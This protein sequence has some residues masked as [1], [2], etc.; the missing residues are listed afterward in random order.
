MPSSPALSRRSG[1][2]TPLASPTTTRIRTHNRF[3][4]Y[5]GD[6]STSEGEDDAEILRPKGKLAARMLSGNTEPTADSESEK[7]SPKPSSPKKTAATKEAEDDGEDEYEIIAPRPRKLKARLQRSATP[8]QEPTATAPRS[9]SPEQNHS[10]APQEIF[11]SPSKP[12]GEAGIYDE[13]LP[14]PSRLAKNAKFEALVAKKRAERLTREAEEARKKA[15]RNAMIMDDE[16]PE[17]FTDDEGGHKLTQEGAKSRPSTRKASKKALEEMNR[18]TQRMTRALQLAHEAKIKKKITKSTLFER[19]NFKPAGAAASTELPKEKAAPVS[20]SRA[21]TPASVQQSDAERK[22][23]D[24]PPSSPPE[25]EKEKA[26]PAPQTILQDNSDVELPTVGEMA[27]SA[28][29][30]PKKL[31]KGKGKA[32][33][34]E[35]EAEDKAKEQHQMPRVK[36]NLRVKFPQFSV[37]A[38]TATTSLDDEDDDLQVQM[39]SKIDQ[40]LSRVNPNQNKE[41]KALLNLRRLAQLD[42]PDKKAGPVPTKQKFQQNQKPVMTVGELQMTLMQRAKAQAKLERERHLESLRA[43][44]IVV[45]TAEEREKEEQEVED[46]V[47]KARREAEEIM[48]KERADAKEERR[49]KRLENGEDPLD[50]DDSDYDGESWIGEGE[51][52]AEIELS[53]SEE[54]NEDEEAEMED[55]G[56]LIDD[57]TEEST[58]EETEEVDAPNSD[59]E[60]GL[61]TASSKQ[62]R[63]RAWK[64]TAVLSDDEDEADEGVVKAT[65]N[66]KKILVKSPSVRQ[67]TSPSVPTSVLRSATKTFIPGLPVAGPAGLGLTQIF[68]GTMDDSQMGSAPPDSPSQPRPTFD[69]GAF[70]DSQFSQSVQEPADGIVLNS[71]PAPG[72][73]DAET[74]GIQIQFSQSQVHGFDSFLRDET[75]EATQV[76]ELIEPTQDSGFKNFTPLQRS[77]IEEPASTVETLPANQNSQADS[78]LVRRTGKLRRRAEAAA[79]ENEDQDEIMKDDI[80]T[81]AASSA[82]NAFFAMKEAARKEK[83]RKRKEAFDKKKSKAREMVEEQAEESED[84]YAGLG[85]ADGEDTDEEDAKS[86]QEMIDDET[87]DKAEDERKLAAFYADRERAADEKQVNKLFHDITTGLLRRKRAG[88]WD[89]LDDEDDGG[90]ALRRM[91]RRQFAKMQRAL[92][93]DERISK[94]AENPRNQAFLKTIEDRG[95]DDEMDFIW[96]PPPPAPG[97]DSQNSATGDSSNE[98]VTIPDSQPQEQQQQQQSTNPR[99]TKPGFTNKK[100]PSNIGE[101]RESLSNL[102]EDGPDYKSS[103]VI[104]ATILHSDSE[105]EGPHPS[106]ASS[107]KENSKPQ[108]VDRISLKRTSSNT[109]SSTRLAFAGSS[110]RSSS[111]KIPPLLRRAT[112]NS[113]T[114]SASSAGM[115]STGVTTSNQQQVRAED[116]GIKIK[117]TASKKSGV[118]Y[119]ARGNERLSA[120]AEKEKRREDKKFK[121]A[122]VGERKKAL[123]GMFGGGRFE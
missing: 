107:N 67:H 22:E 41:P 115:S 91:K 47:A 49:K 81:D 48:A 77:F 52:E 112:T 83:E 68:Q 84:E 39:P 70:P 61:F 23:D 106:S 56:V 98:A 121:G 26:T 74:Q 36:R 58:D 24:T 13:D 57:A 50:W 40:I 42:D 14:S 1:S 11:V 85:G 104:S 119:L 6:S 59:D 45:M 111:F 69:M 78:P 55:G 108:I 38:N 116:G 79:S 21:G 10:P 16:D 97:L 122:M 114:L 60:D 33:A 100:K 19:F 82:N 92:F 101:I 80:E 54:E 8:E 64:Q 73:Q 93:A 18:E 34:A 118:S 105:G 4:N 2:A 28:A 110:D 103:S 51:E 29:A 25:G 65:P 3:L 53:G 94:V 44:G 32:T 62:A 7:D 123:G 99:R 27:A 113:S 86:V 87:A 76:S 30:A 102:L 20:S 88:N 90:E 17:N 89:E 95:S 71:Q 120:L 109:S 63:R 31:D 117:Q 66:P 75:F 72:E 46:I 35:F 43:K 12:A 9:P 96:G 37:R 5:G 15:E